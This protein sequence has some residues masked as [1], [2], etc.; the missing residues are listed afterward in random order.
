[1]AEHENQTH[2]PQR[3]SAFSIEGRVR[4]EQAEC[5]AGELELMAYAF[6]HTGRAI[7]NAKVDGEGNYRV[8][9]ALT[10]PSGVELVIGPAGDPQQI[11]RSSAYSEHFSAQDWTAAGERFQL[12]H[13]VVL[14]LH[15]WLPW[16]PKRIC[17]TGHVRKVK[18]HDGITEL[19]PVPYVKVEIFDVDREA[20]WW[21][22]LRKWWDVLADRPVVRIPD[23]MKDRPFPKPFPEPDPAPD[24]NLRGM[25]DT[26]A[27]NPQPLPPGLATS[28]MHAGS[29]ASF[30]P[31]PEPPGR[32][33]S[34]EKAL[35]RVGETSL[36]STPLAARFDKL[37][38][39]SKLAPWHIFPHCF[40]SKVEVC[41]TTT[42]CNGFFKCCFNWWPFHFRRG[43]LRFDSRPDIIIKVTQVIN[44]VPTVI[45]MDPYTSTR[46]NVSNAHIDLFLD[47]EE[48]ICGSGHCHEPPPGS[49]VFFTRIGN[50]EV[51]QINQASGLYN[52]AT[53]SNV[54]YGDT[55]SVYGQ[56]GDALTGGD[57]AQV[58]GEPYFYY[59]LSYAKQGSSDGDY[60]FID[61]DLN[62]TR[63]DKAT[64]NA[65]SHKLG[66]YTV[67]GISSLYEVRN[68]SD[69]FWYNPDWI[70]TWNTLVAEEDTDTYVLRLE[71]FDQN[72]NKLNTA[73]GQVDYRNGAGIGN[74]LPPTP[75]PAMV[76]HSDLVITLDNKPPVLD[77][78]IPA[79]LNECGVI[80]WSN[81]PPLDF[82]VSV[83]QE[84]ARLH[85]WGLQYTKGV[86]PTV[87]S[88]ASV[89][90]NAGALSPVNTIV[91]GMPLLV[92]L[93]STCAFALKLWAWPH[94]R[95]GYGF[96]YYK[97]QIKAIAIEKCS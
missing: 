45:Y 67:N 76:D 81:V 91:N 66:P 19:C 89:S 21:P 13:D 40:Y 7:G 72:G 50:D 52:D 71:L 48:V 65:E 92:G 49:V 27:L 39:T 44:G 85:S 90:S 86:N 36:L 73:S 1:M 64:L 29:M 14:P 60:K 3:E 69:Y 61:A 18:H 16:W 53:Y 9:V 32:S 84:N 10:K 96:I 24:F 20:C 23:L 41:E 87:N 2:S 8:A 68:S 15:V 56:F 38:L 28:V 46:W 47:N 77:L 31:Q 42:D 25:S 37:T 95:N 54:A 5:Q 11:R 51:Y 59:R 75:L 78:Q 33:L 34:M 57:P 82:D 58:D 63:I 97:E 6:D 79:V 83:I 94:I 22:W 55:L 43:R 26:V 17:I 80:P 35:M 74:G 30:D 62:D 88:L 70:G 12:R 4:R 93:N